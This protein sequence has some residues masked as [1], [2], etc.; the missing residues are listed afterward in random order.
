MRVD[1]E[2]YSEDYGEGNGEDVD[3][4]CGFIQRQDRI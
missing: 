3:V 2:E 4:W 1:G